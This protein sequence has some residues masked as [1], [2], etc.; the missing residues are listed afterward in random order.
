[1]VEA[2][3]FFYLSVLENQLSFL[4]CSRNFSPVRLLFLSNLMGNFLFLINV[5]REPSTILGALNFSLDFLADMLSRL[6]FRR[7]EP[8][9]VFVASPYGEV[10]SRLMVKF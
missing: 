7:G 9:F 1:M 10:E 6:K 8:W 5:D 4:D 3:A 2:F